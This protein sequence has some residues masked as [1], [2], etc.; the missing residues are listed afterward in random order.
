MNRSLK[1]VLF[2]LVF[3]GIL[4][5][6]FWVRLQPS[7]STGDRSSERS[8]QSPLMVHA[9]V[10]EPEMFTEHFVTTGSV[11]ADEQVYIRPETSGRVTGVFFHEDS[12][13]NEGDL[14]IKMQDDDLQQEKRRL[15]YEIKLA[16]I[17][18]NRQKTLLERDAIPQ[19]EYDVALN[20]LNTLRAQR[21]RIQVS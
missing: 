4:L 12:P 13:V 11:R 5:I 2:P 18:K 17:R 16:E 9:V 21:D 19:E 3:V 6:L 8:S 7:D 20:Q 15:S 14:L 1:K 10:T